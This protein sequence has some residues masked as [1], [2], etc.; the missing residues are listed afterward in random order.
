MHRS[1]SLAPLQSL[2][3]VVVA[4]NSTQ[5]G[6]RLGSGSWVWHPHLVVLCRG[7]LGRHVLAGHTTDA[8]WIAKIAAM[9]ALRGWSRVALFA[10]DSTASQLCD[11]TR[12][13]PPIS[14]L[15]IPYRAALLTTTLRM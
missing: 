10:S 7:W 5:K 9:F 6:T 3:F 4:C 2:P 11:L 1:G 8:E 14:A 13:P 12:C 15:S